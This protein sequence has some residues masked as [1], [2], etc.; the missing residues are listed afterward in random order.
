V[1][2]SQ[3]D[4]EKVQSEGI[5]NACKGNPERGCSEFPV[6]TRSGP[7]AEV[8]DFSRDDRDVLYSDLQRMDADRRSS[9]KQSFKTQDSHYER[10][11]NRS[12][13][14]LFLG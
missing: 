7:K 9:T 5:E 1:R 14:D 3:V 4:V 2:S 10:R 13:F 8:Q 6:F 12:A 11:S